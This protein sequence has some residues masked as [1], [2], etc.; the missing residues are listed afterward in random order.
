MEPLLLTPEQAFNLIGVGRSHGYKLLA[1][2]EIPS[3]KL[4]RLRRI[5]RAALEQWVADSITDDD[6]PLPTL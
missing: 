6:G 5:P 1:S 3:L 2:G 4:G